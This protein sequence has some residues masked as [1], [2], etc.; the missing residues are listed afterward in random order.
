MI[1]SMSTEEN[2]ALVRRLYGIVNQHK[3]GESLGAKRGSVTDLY[4]PKWLAHNLPAIHVPL[5][6]LAAFLHGRNLRQ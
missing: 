2:K 3:L 6:V 1:K 5:L 4:L